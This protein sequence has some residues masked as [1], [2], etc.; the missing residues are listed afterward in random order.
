MSLSPNIVAP[1]V[2][3]ASLYS[4]NVRLV[5]VGF[6]ATVSKIYLQELQ[7]P[8]AI[9]RID[10]EGGPKVPTA[11]AYGTSLSQSRFLRGDSSRPFMKVLTLKVGKSA[12]TLYPIP[13]KVDI[14][15]P[16]DQQQQAEN[17]PFLVT[18]FD[19]HELTRV[20]SEIQSYKDIDPYKGSGIHICDRV[21]TDTGETFPTLSKHSRPLKE[22][23]K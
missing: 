4:I 19:W 8:F 3:K 2:S 11:G 22:I 5:G 20:V 16:T 10:P 23:K 1:T 15:C 21:E 9:R 6:R 17:Q 12:S 18:S 13:S 14:Y 7:E